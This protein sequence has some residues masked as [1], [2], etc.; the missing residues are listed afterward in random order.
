MP[1]QVSI[2]VLAEAPKSLGADVEVRVGIP[3]RSPWTLPFAYKAVLR[4]QQDSHDLFVYLED[5]VRVT[6]ANIQAFLSHARTLPPDCIPGFTRYERDERGNKF[7]VDLFRSFHFEP[8]SVV[9]FGERRYVELSN[10]H[11]ACFMLTHGAFLAAA[12]RHPS[13]FADPAEGGATSIR[14]P[15]QPSRTRRVDCASYCRSMTSMISHFTTFLTSITASKRTPWRPSALSSCSSS[16]YAACAASPGKHGSSREPASRLC[17]GTRP[18][19]CRPTERRSAAFGTTSSEC[20][21]W[22]SGS[23][24]L[25]RLWRTRAEP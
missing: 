14:R 1:F 6:I 17:T 7:Y 4:E 5:D 23:A 12:L 24:P 15:R 10:L 21:R 3:G 20:F 13:F 9:D 19:T 18:T 8:E 22:V 11:A 2:V 25:R 16:S